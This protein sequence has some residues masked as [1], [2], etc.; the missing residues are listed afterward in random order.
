MKGVRFCVLTAGCAVLLLTSGCATMS[1]SAKSENENLK[2]QIQ[3]LEAQLRQK[4]AELD[5]MRQ[6]LSRTTEEK[7]TQ[8]RSTQTV[9]GQPT[10]KQIQ[11]ALKNAG[12]DPGSVDGQMGSKTRRAIRDF[13]KANDLSADGK[14]G[15]KTW[16]VLSLYLER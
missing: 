15:R 12:F 14:V 2:I 4:D 16:S 11:T 7:Y 8:M 5:S 1:K 13:Q 9:S 6:S 3:N 10:V